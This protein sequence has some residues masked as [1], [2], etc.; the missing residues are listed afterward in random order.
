M[1]RVKST[2]AKSVKTASSLTTAKPTGQ[3]FNLTGATMDTLQSWHNQIRK[4]MHVRL[5]ISHYILKTFKFKIEDFMDF[6]YKDLLTT[7]N[8]GKN[9]SFITSCQINS[10]SGHWEIGGH[11]MLKWKNEIYDVNDYF[12]RIPDPFSK[13]ART[14]QFT[15]TPSGQSI[16]PNEIDLKDALGN[17]YFVFP[18]RELDLSP[19]VM[20][21][22]LSPDSE[23]IL[24]NT[25]V[26]PKNATKFGKILLKY[27]LT[28]ATI[29]HKNPNRIRKIC[30]AI[31]QM[32]NNTS[33]GIC[34]I[35]TIFVYCYIKLHGNTNGYAIDVRN[36]HEF[37]AFV[38]HHVNLY[39]R[40]ISKNKIATPCDDMVF[41]SLADYM[42]F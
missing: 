42:N 36:Y 7:H 37:R 16:N 40:D 35:V 13:T 17:P 27:G 20:T 19:L 8:N 14:L 4:N 25:M 18:I 23:D 39:I 38:A 6:D 29:P 1:P 32:F 31:H 22:N 9:I 12:D 41:E 5:A 28:D 15:K 21:N 30:G 26:T 34:T 2:P 24:M 3:P 10:N 33:G 11:M